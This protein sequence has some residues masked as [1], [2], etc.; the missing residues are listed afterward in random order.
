MAEKNRG[1]ERR[2]KEEERG[3]ATYGGELHLP[4]RRCAK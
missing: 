1:E 4:E 3:K 2:I